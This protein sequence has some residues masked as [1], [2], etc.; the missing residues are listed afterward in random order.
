M[1]VTVAGLLLNLKLVTFVK[2]ADPG[3]IQKG[4][5]TYTELCTLWKIPKAIRKIES[6]AQRVSIFVCND[7]MFFEISL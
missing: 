3:R 7:A 2:I 1:Y 6:A 5:V 4:D